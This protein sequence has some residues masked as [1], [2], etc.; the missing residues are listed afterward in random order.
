M[1]VG[2]LRLLALLS[3]LL[4][5]LTGQSA[6][7]AAKHFET[8]Y[9]V[10]I[11]PVDS[12]TVYRGSV[13]PNGTVLV[14]NTL[15]DVALIWADGSVLRRNYPALQ[16]ALGNTCSDGNIAYISA[17]GGLVRSF[18]VLQAGLVEQNVL[19]A[20]GSRA[21]LLVADSQLFVL[22]LAPKRTAPS[23]E[24]LRVVQLPGGANARSVPIDLPLSVGTVYNELVLHGTLLFQKPQ[25]RVLYIPYNP[26]EVWCLNPAGDVQEVIHPQTHHRRAS[27]YS[28]QPTAD[29][30]FWEREDWVTSAAVLPD[31]RLIAEIHRGAARGNSDAARP[32]H[33]EIFDPTFHLIADDVPLPTAVGSLLGADSAGFVY[34]MS[35]SA[36]RGV[37]V[38]KLALA[39]V[40][41]GQTQ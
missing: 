26:F 18:A 9:S 28:G 19:F 32:N 14:T 37:S 10:D 20:G 33:V 12:S 16:G 25:H 11:W 30:F 22:G 21:G 6:V 35:V 40:G 17:R 1:S 34:S 23:S 7:D 4:R 38:T 5:L 3:V 8:R 13:C 2:T 27:I 41:P 39:M 31:G 29:P 36:S 24:Y 15:G